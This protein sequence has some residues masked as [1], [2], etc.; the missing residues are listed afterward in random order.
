M[1]YR[2]KDTT[3][4]EFMVKDPYLIYITK[5]V[6]YN[7]L[8]DLLNRYGFLSFPVVDTEGKFYISLL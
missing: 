8:Q 3:A 4:K 1:F 5:R 6:S 7:R 2:V